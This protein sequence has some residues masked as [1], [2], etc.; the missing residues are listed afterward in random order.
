M[1]LTAHDLPPQE[2]S[3]LDFIN[4]APLPAGP[5]DEL[6][7]RLEAAL[8]DLKALIVADYQPN[9]IFADRSRSALNRLAAA[10][11]GVHFVVDSRDAIGSFQGMALKPNETEAARH[12]FPGQPPEAVA[13]QALEEAARAWQRQVGRPIVITRGARGCMLVAGEIVH[14]PAGQVPPPIDPV[15]AGDTFLAALAAGLGAGAQP[16]E[17]CAV[18]NLAAAVTIQQLRVTGTASPAQI[19]GQFD[20]AQP[21]SSPE[22]TQDAPPSAA[23]DR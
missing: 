12:L 16:W 8:P 14:L 9:G 13:P 19:L 5:V 11:P 1:I 6:L 23:G 7:A 2:D 17:A 22:A 3:R 21:A 4:P 10:H 18:A 20:A 15:G